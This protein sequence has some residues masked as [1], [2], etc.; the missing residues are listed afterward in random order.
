MINS[1]ILYLRLGFHVIGRYYIQTY[2]CYLNTLSLLLPISVSS[3]YY[4]YRERD[5]RNTPVATRPNMPVTRTLQT[6]TWRWSYCAR[7]DG[8]RRRRPQSR[9]PHLTRS[10][11]SLSYSTFPTTTQMT[12]RYS[13]R[14][15]TTT[16]EAGEGAGSSGRREA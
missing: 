11:T 10:I 14:S 6:R 8:S 3:Y 13:S 1:H 16:G 2:I 9:R 5:A 15:L 12:S 4:I 7:A